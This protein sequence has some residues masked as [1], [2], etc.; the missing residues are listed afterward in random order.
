MTV[1]IGFTY[2]GE[3]APALHGIDLSLHPGSMTAVLGPVGAG[4]STLCRVLAGLADTRGTLTGSVETSG[5][6]ALLGDDPEA[7]LSGMT[8][9]VSD[10]TQLACRLHGIAPAEAG[11]RARRT[12]AHL[13]LEHLWHRQLSTLSGGQR[14]LTALARIIAAEPELLIL[15]Q[16]TQS[17]DPDMRRRVT[18]LLGEF[19]DR[20]G[21]VLVTGHQIDELSGACDEVRAL[22]SGELLPAGSSAQASGVWDSRPDTDN[23]RTAL[24]DSEHSPEASAAV[25]LP[26]AATRALGG[27]GPSALSVKG[28]SVTRGGTRT[29]D[30]LDLDVAPGELVTV[31]GANGAGK[32]TLLRAL[33]GLLEP[34]A[35]FTGQITV[36]HLGEAV[37]LTASPTH[38]R[39]PHI[40]WVG[41]DPGVQLSAATVRSELEHAAPLPSHR[42]KDRRQVRDQRSRLVED[43]LEETGLSAFSEDHPFDLDVPRRKD[44][45]IATALIT[46]ARVLLLDE[47]TIGRDHA[48]MRRLTTIIDRF[49]DR[50]GAVLATTHDQRWAQEASHRLLRLEHGRVHQ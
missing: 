12:L 7:Q 31:S 2:S 22:D 46:G 4:T 8:S 49:L 6:T 9:S 42:R 19:T 18:V 26:A 43:V 33:L 29:L 38:I 24:A 39:A 10:E 32:S 37:D 45:V 1:G 30:D 5:T 41:Q 27:R 50:G 47:P 34:S 14:Q 15:D 13:G 21:A 35:H 40:G 23:E 48:G 11:R 20:G 44:V 36:S 17:L 3:D 28:L 16:P 25:P